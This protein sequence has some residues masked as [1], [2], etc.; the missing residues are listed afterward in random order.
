M[1]KPIVVVCERTTCVVWRVNEYALHLAGKILL[2]GFQ[3]QQ[4]VAK[5]QVIIEAVLFR[6]AKPCMIAMCG[7]GEQYTWL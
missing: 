7:V 6:N 3:G 4:V 2:K 5:D 1:L